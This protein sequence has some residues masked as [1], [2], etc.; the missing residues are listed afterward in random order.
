VFE[1]GGS[2]WLLRSFCFSMDLL[3]TL[4]L[5]SDVNNKFSNINIYLLTWI[6]WVETAENL[7]SLVYKF[8]NDSAYKHNGR[9]CRILNKV[10]MTTL[11]KTSNHSFPST[12]F[13]KVYAPSFFSWLEHNYSYLSLFTGIVKITSCHKNFCNKFK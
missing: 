1:Q 5:P 7:I 13:H 2:K 6:W 11:K 3:S 10:N 9:H 4:L 12:F 8:S